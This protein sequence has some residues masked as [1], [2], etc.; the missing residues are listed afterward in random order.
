MLTGGLLTMF[1][2]AAPADVPPADL[3]EAV[4][5]LVQGL[6]AAEKV[7]RD[8]AERQLLQLGPAAI[9]ALPEI[10]DRMG[11]ETALRLRRVRV[12]LEKAAAE[13]SVQAAVVSLSEPK[14]PLGEVLRA[15]TR[16][17]GN[18]LVDFRP[19]FGEEPRDIP[20]AVRFDKTPF[21]QALDQ[22]LDQARLTI[23]R[24]AGEDGLAVVG[25]S[26]SQLPRYGRAAYVGAFRVEGTDFTAHRD[27][28]D[29]MSHTL[30]LNVEVAWEPRLRPI[31]IV[32]AAD[33]VSAVDEQGRT[34]ALAGENEALE[35]NVTPGASSVELPI[36]LALPPRS[37]GKLARLTGRLAVLLPGRVEEFRFAELAKARNV[38]VRKGAATVTL[39]HVWKNNEVWE[40]RMRVA[41]DKADGALESHRT[42]VFNN[43]AWL[44]NAQREKVLPAGLETTRQTENE[45]GVAYLFSVPAGLAGQTFVYRTPA[46]VVSQPVVYELKDLELP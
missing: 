26:P 24:F 32:Q 3:R 43:E 31:V 40:V 30:Q 27:L 1:L 12:Q 46:A 9:E 21:W 28:R 35:I 18:K 45:V 22:V 41:F 16:Q 13:A 19:Q 29:P 10:D 39:D 23:Y 34:V 17:T 25:R 33:A 15:L 37:V 36:S 5:V 8:E 11:A 38:Q 6:D 4:K 44:E 42:W 20:L 14:L 2:V 7:R